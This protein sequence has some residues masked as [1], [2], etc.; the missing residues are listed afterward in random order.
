MI[1]RGR[2]WHG[3]VRLGLVRQCK[4]RKIITALFGWVRHGK[5]WAGKVRQGKDMHDM[6]NI[7]D[8]HNSYDMARFGTV[9]SG[10][11]RRGIKFIEKCLSRLGWVRHGVVR[12][13][14]ARLCGDVWSG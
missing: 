12:L 5:V 10:P 2:V 9:L 7:D 6:G 14:E 1:W 8:M 3:A 4:A 13:G 11:V